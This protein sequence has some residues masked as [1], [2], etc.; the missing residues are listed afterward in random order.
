[1]KV[2]VNRLSG[3]FQIMGKQEPYDGKRYKRILYC[4]MQKV[5]DGMLAFNTLTREV[6]LLTDYEVDL[7]NGDIIFRESDRMFRYLIEHWYYIPEDVDDFSFCYS[8]RN[9]YVSSEM[10]R[11]SLAVNTIT[12]LTTT[13][14][15]AR[16]PYCYE[17]GIEKYSM[18]EQVAKDTADYILNNTSGQVTLRWF[19]GEPL[20]NTGAMDTISEALKSHDVNYRSSITS[21]GMLFDLFSDKQ[22]IELWRI[23][24]AQI[25]LDGTHD[26]YN[27]VK[28][29]VNVTDDPYNRVLENIKRL[30]SLGI[31]IMIRLNI[32]NENVEDMLN[33]V[34]EL[35]SKFGTY[36]NFKVYPH[37]VF[38]GAGKIPYMP[39]DEEREHLFDN[40]IQV[41]EKTVQCNLDPEHRVREIMSH[42]CMADSGNSRVIFP[43]GRISLCQ[44]YNDEEVCGTIY[45]RRLDRNKIAEWRKREIE[46][47]ACLSCAQYPICFRLEKCPNEVICSSGERR[48]NEMKIRQ[49]LKRA[50]S[51]YKNKNGVI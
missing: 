34:D 2:V 47:S 32:S 39:T 35:H 19:G 8:I 17:Y 51:N 20:C 11:R 21:N 26:I 15:N 14:C 50:Y 45:Q 48:F 49:E 12:V 7:F 13:S 41:Y 29:Y 42:H 27:S 40:C 1:M 43:D 37:P 5:N 23:R 18:T 33:L 25:T 22:I 30:L 9:G 24:T 3:V 16:C 46:T 38:E 44:H 31:R 28:G 6:L 36:K 4:I 10:G